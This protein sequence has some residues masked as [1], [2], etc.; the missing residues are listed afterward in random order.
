MKVPCWWRFAWRF[1]IFYQQCSTDTPK[2]WLQKLPSRVT[3]LNAN[4]SSCYIS[5]NF[6]IITVNLLIHE[7]NSAS[8]W[9]SICNKCTI[10]HFDKYSWAVLVSSGR[11]SV[12]SHII[13]KLI[14]WCDATVQSGRTLPVLLAGHVWHYSLHTPTC[15]LI[16][17][18][19]M[20]PV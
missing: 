3:L 11:R 20:M 13:T 15:N 6:D 7:Y 17:Y 19:N 9:L 16:C 4:T 10:H 18:H 12:A 14:F 1:M 5:C 8:N 2:V